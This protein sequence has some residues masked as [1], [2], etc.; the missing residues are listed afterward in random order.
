MASS[1]Q[2]LAYEEA[3]RHITEQHGRLE[4]L[5]TRAAALLSVASLVTSFLGGQALTNTTTDLFGLEVSRPSLHGWA[6]VAVI[7]FLGSCG[8]CVWILLP[9]RKGWR[10]GFNA[11]RLIRDYVDKGVELDPMY[12][13]LALWLSK[14][15]Q[16]NESK[17]EFRYT[18][19]QVGAVLIGI[20]VV[21]GCST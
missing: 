21:L 4:S 9:K 19:L 11:K 12:R 7:A 10:F 18:L 20:E 15:H 16:E 13:E 17:L 6:V 14:Y 1:P 2:A 5:R 8:A 3:L